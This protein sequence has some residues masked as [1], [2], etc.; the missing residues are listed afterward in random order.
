VVFNK[1]TAIV[2]FAFTF[3]AHALDNQFICTFDA[4]VKISSLNPKEP[5]PIVDKSTTDKYTF[6]IDSVNPLKASYI[7]L[8]SGLKIQLHAARNGNAFIFTESNIGGNHF[9]VSVFTEK[10][11]RDGFN[12]VMSFHNDQPTDANDYYAQS[13]RI[14]RCF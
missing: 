1:L 13:I 8:S 11:F 10:K 4:T 12:A 6:M 5:K 9:V 3:S 14:G 2:L 7:N